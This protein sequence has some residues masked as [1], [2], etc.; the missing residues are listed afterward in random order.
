M[1][2]NY[3][4]GLLSRSPSRETGTT[5]DFRSDEERRIAEADALSDR[6]NAFKNFFKRWPRFY[7]RL[8]LFVTPILFTGLTGESFA[9]RFEKDKILLNIGSGPTRLHANMVN[10]DLYPFQNVDVLS[11]GEALPFL[12]CI[13][14]GAVCDQVLEHVYDPEAVVREIVRVM[15]PGGLIYLGVPFMYPLHP[16]P[17]DYIRWSQEGVQRLLPGCDIIERGNAMGPTSGLLVVVAA[18]LA[19]VFSFGLTPLRKGLQYVFML[20]LFPFKYLDVIF[21]R[22]PGAETIAAAVYVVARKQ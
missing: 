6:E 18:W 14:D 9:R 15:K 13:F 21:A 19:L 5:L 11:R 10:V 4:R 17:K 1:D 2:Q 12:E 16:S 3:L 22:F 8:A 20:L 7:D